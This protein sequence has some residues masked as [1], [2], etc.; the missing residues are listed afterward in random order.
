MNSEEA[1]TPEAPSETQAR[2]STSPRSAKRVAPRRQSSISHEHRVTLMALTAG[3]P[4]SMV[5]LWLLWGGSYTA[6]VQLTLTMLLVGV[7]AG[8]ASR[9]V[10]ASRA[11]CKPSLISWRRCAKAITRSVRVARGVMMLWAK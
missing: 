6:K 1:L 11:R 3:L 10:V 9:C 4:G 7:W 8:A 5:A 2:A